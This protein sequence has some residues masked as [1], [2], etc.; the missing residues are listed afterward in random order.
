MA[1]SQF[2][3]NISHDIRTPLTAVLGY[4]RMLQEAPLKGKYIEQL[5]RLDQASGLL[6][7]LVNDVLDWSKIEAGEFELANE[8]FNLSNSC[9]TLFS[10]MEGQALD[11]GLSFSFGRRSN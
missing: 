2:I 4:N 6:L 11:K 5:K 10:V 9:D 1:R 8:P 3:A 7:S